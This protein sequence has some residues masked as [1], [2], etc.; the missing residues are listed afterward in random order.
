MITWQCIYNRPVQGKTLSVFSLWSGFMQTAPI[1]NFSL[2][3][4]FITKQVLKCDS[5]YVVWKW[6]SRHVTVAEAMAWIKHTKIPTLRAVVCGFFLP[7]QGVVWKLHAN[8]TA[9]P[10]EQNKAFVFSLFYVPMFCHH[11]CCFHTTAIL[12]VWIHSF[13]AFNK[14]LFVL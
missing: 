7:L 14:C 9:T 5:R 1:M 4:Q 2:G 12:Q 10:K 6:S 8:A 3:N 11:H 13:H